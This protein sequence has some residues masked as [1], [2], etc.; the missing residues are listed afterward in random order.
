MAFYVYLYRDP[1]SGV[2]VYVGKGQGQRAQSHLTGTANLLFWRFLIQC[3]N[4][5]YDVQP[6]IVFDDLDEVTALACEAV[7]IEKFGRRIRGTGSLFNRASG[8]LSLA[9]HAATDIKGDPEFVQACTA[10][11]QQLQERAEFLR[12]CS[13]LPKRMSEHQLRVK[14]AQAQKEWEKFIPNWRNIEPDPEPKKRTR[15]RKRKRVHKSGSRRK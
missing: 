7:L 1:V 9:Q 4:A 12:S 5:G 6:E 8:S 13:E 10:R 2:P 3:Q 14:A 11:L 15:R